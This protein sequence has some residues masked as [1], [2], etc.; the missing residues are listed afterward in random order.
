MMSLSLTIGHPG[1]TAAA[2]TVTKFCVDVMG[3]MGGASGCLRLQ[4]VNK[5]GTSGQLAMPKGLLRPRCPPNL[6]SPHY[7]VRD[8]TATASPPHSSCSESITS[9]D[10]MATFSSVGVKQGLHQVN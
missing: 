10:V 2:L 4:W 7:S 6:G 8:E 3:A 5:E 9:T 1:K